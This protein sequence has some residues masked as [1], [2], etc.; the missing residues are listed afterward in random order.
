MQLGPILF[1]GMMA[2][3]GHSIQRQENDRRPRASDLMD[4]RIACRCTVTRLTYLGQ[5]LDI[6]PFHPVAR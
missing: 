5:T 2:V 1:E 4:R 3:G 6:A